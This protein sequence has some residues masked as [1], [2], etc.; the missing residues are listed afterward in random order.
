MTKRTKMFA[1]YNAWANR[2]LYGAASQLPDGDYR[3][4]RGAFFKS[5]HG[6]L[7][8]ILVGDKIWMRR[9]TGQGDAPS[10]LDLIL[11]DNLPDLWAA[12]QMEDERIQAYAAA[13]DE[14]ALSGRLRF[15]TIVNPQTLEQDLEP[16]LDHFFNHK[17]HHR[18]QVHCL[19]THFL[20]NAAVPSLDMIIFQRETGQGGTAAR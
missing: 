1:D 18:G 16:A 7:N 3:C 11:H 13:L 19:L 20:G 8:H 10:Q 6:T 14:T 5:V 4:N 12:R 9:F 17:T 2:R 15:T